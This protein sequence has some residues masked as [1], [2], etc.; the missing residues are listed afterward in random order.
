MA[1]RDA[2]KM[3]APSK[4]S[5]AVSTPP[6]RARNHLAPR[7]AVILAIVLGGAL[8]LMAQSGF[9]RAV[10]LMPWP[11]GLEYAAAAVNLDQGAGA[12]LHFGGYS[13]PSRY[14]QGYPLILAAAF[15]LLGH[16]VAN[17]GYATVALAMLAIVALYVLTLELFGRPAAAVAS[18]LLAASPVFIT[19][20]TLVM[21]D[22]PALAVTILA[23]LAMLRATRAAEA[24]S[25]SDTAVAYWAIFGFLAGFSVMIRPTNATIVIGAAAALF[26]APPIASG[27]RRT[28]ASLAAFAVG[29]APMLAWQARENVAHLGSA[30]ASGYAWWVPEVYGTFSRTF[31]A[32]YLLGP[33]MPRNPSGNLPVYL[34]ALCGLD[35]FSNGAGAPHFYLYPFSAAV[36]AA[37][38]L[39]SAIRA[40]ENRAARR[41]VFLGA[42]FLGALL[43][44]YIFYVFTEVAFILPGCFIIFAAAGHG[45]AI[46]NR[47]LF[48]LRSQRRRSIAEHSIVAAVALLDLLLAI[49]IARDVADR[50]AV[51]PRQS[52]I[53]PALRTLDRNLEPGAVIVSNVALQFLELYVPA[54]GRTF[55]GLHSFDPGGE[56]TDYHLARLFAKKSRDEKSPGA[57]R[58]TGSIPP[59]LFD[60]A[61]IV[62]ATA[63]SL[64]A[65][66]R[67]G[68]P[69]DLLLWTAG[70]SDYAQILKDE[71]D[72]LGD[73]FT[74]DETSRAGPLVLYRL[75]LR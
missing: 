16:D 51:P 24:R 12:V 9:K 20:S 48:A 32:A 61:G 58:W 65:Q 33:T 13:Y 56:F 59:A 21:S 30:F 54:P 72:R 19:Y 37:I 2:L 45:A 52:E 7:D 31:N 39:V 66:A 75:K 62:N 57:R 17:L 23:A 15:P 74:L 34:L 68:T 50:I 71:L 64:A 29:F 27:S 42:G 1:C 73:R 43:A 63:D 14:T 67:A 46:A 5:A 49:A 69:I 4:R 6:P 36:F 28:R 22:V 8:M 11:D 26:A 44:V 47:E 10:E 40:T 55:L 18:A 38:G 53:V 70:D 25:A 41:V 3:P 60:A 35:G